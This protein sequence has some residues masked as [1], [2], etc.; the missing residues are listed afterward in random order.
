MK[1]SIITINLNNKAGLQKTID[2][3]V[4]Q[5]FKDFEWIVIDGGSTDGSKELIEQYVGHFAYWVSEPDNGIYNAMNKGIKVAKGEYLQF[6]NSGDWLVDETALERCFSHGFTADIAYG[7]LWLCE[8]EVR[9]R[10][11]YPNQLTLR[12]LYDFS[13]G[14]CA[15]FIR[16]EVIEN[17]LYDERLKI[18]SDWEF[19]LKQALN[20]KT[21]E[22][23]DED[24]SC[25]DMSG[26]SC[27]NGQL[28]NQ[29]RNKVLKEL[30]PNM[31]VGD[32]ELMDEMQSKLN[33]DR[34]KAVMRYS[35]KTLYR[36]MITAC[37]SFIGFIDKN[38][39]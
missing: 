8:G 7:D 29:E 14:H 5:T 36:K 31:L 25:F 34:I 28:V 17:E 37:L 26:V 39:A 27:K 20:N 9:E 23:I 16:K 3:V 30:I 2:S 22:Y 1:L 18:V 33:D 4:S 35:E 15:S 24:V 38:F 21:F 13:L 11:N 10:Y 6:L 32:Y 12:F 19:Y